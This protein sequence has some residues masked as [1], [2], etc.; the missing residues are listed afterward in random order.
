MRVLV[1]TT[2]DLRTQALRHDIRRVD[3]ILFTHAH[4]DH[5]MGLDEVR[6]YNMLSRRAD[7]GLRR[8]A[9]AR[10][11]A[12]DVQLR[13]SSR[14]R[15]RAAACRTCGC[16]R[17]AGRSRSAARKS[18]R[19][20]SG[21]AVGRSSGSG[22]AASRISPTATAFPTS[23]LALLE[24]PRLLV[25]DALRHRPHPTHFTLDR[26][27]RRWRGAIGARADATSRTSR[28]SSATQA[29]CAHAARR[30]GAGAR[31]PR[32]R[33]RVMQIVYFPDAPPPEVAAS[34][35][36]A[37]QL[38]RAASRAPAA[39]RRGA[40]PGAAERGGHVGRDDLRSASAAGAAAGQG[41]AAAD[42]ARS[43]A[44][45]VRARRP[46]RRWPS[47]GS[48]RS[49]RGGSRR[50]FVET[51]L[52]DWLRVVGG[53]GRRQLPVRPR[54][55]RARSRCCARSAR[56][57]ASA[58]RRSSRCATRTSSC[59]ARAIRH[60]VAEGAWTR[61]ARCSAITTSIDGDGRARRRPR[62]RARVS[63]REPRDGQ[64]AAAGLRHLRDDGDRR[65]RVAS[66]GDERRRPADD[67]RRP[68]H[69]RDAP[70]RRGARPVRRAAC[71]WRSSSGCGEELQFDGLDAL[72]GADR[73]RLRRGPRRCSHR[74]AI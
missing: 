27:G 64:R 6:R 29:T 13:R 40:A 34:G 71:G 3:A 70:A 50:L 23:S 46:R 53:L 74:M 32:G 15:R 4:A 31:R 9:D 7:A 12:A 59:R 62:P 65:R 55:V 45:G 18:C 35:R 68:A 61:P 21:T 51:V 43:E 19:C 54:P 10:R 11:A 42:D 26:G 38:R 14:T 8:R 36:R 48:R 39:H 44:R 67:R 52:I 16:G 30:H 56:T 49:C 41:A 66:G 17:S 69:G 28:T 20:R 57:A 24:R 58:S 25:L 37:R 73:A 47:S 5:I 60:L 33:G 72:Q 2:P 63:H 22:S 1:D